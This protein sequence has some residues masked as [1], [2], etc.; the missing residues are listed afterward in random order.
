MSDTLAIIRGSLILLFLIAGLG[1]VAV[2]LL[3][4]SEDP[5]RLIFKW[6]LSLVILGIIITT[7]K[8]GIF[9][10]MIALLGAIGFLLIWGR[11]VGEV[12][13]RPLTG[14]FDGGGVPLEPQPLYSIA[15]AKRKRG[16]YLEALA[17]VRKEL[18]Q[19]PN[20]VAGQLLLAEIQAVDL[21]DLPGAETTLQRLCHQPGHAPRNIAEALNQLADWHLKYSQDS[22]AARQTLER[23]IELLPDTEQAQMAAQRIALL[24]GTDSLIAAHDRKPIHLPAGIQNVGLLQQPANLAQPEAD[25]AQKASEYVRHLEQHPLDFTAREQLA[26]LYA[27]HYGRLELALDQLEQIVQQPHQPAKEVVS[28]L[29]RQAELQIKHGSDVDQ[30]RQTIQRIVDLFPDTAAAQIARQRLDHLQ[31]ELKGKEKSQVLKL[32]SYEQNIGLKSAKGYG[33]I[34]PRE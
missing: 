5:A 12:I 30:A 16:R 14:I 22:E 23:I 8:P 29:N 26:L 3:K 6:V 33:G 13:A 18:E 15:Q 25:P 31:L 34:S 2:W 21:Q 28:A 19:F 9:G 10:L 4:R 32:V 27:D 11:S 7:A 1:W 17:D 20:D 24:A